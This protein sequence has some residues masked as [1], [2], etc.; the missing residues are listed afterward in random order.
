MWIAPWLSHDQRNVDPPS[1][2]HP[3]P[4]PPPSMSIHLMMRYVDHSLTIHLMIRDMWIASQASISWSEI[5]GSLPD[6]PSEDHPSHDQRYMDRS[7]TIHLKN[8]HL[9][10]RDI[11]IAPWLSIWR[12]SISWSE[13]YGSLPDYPSEDHP[14][15]DQ[16]YMDRSLTIHLMIIHLMIRDIWIAPWLSIWRPSISWS[17]IYGSLPD[18]PSHDHPSQG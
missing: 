4:P 8:I 11:W 10:I 12:P 14:S 1:S 2:L 5:Y 3:T 15:H 17:E 13:I 7:L 9:M 16:R 6:Y 18:Y